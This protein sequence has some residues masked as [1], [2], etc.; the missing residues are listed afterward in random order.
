VVE[1][2]WRWIEPRA[3]DLQDGRALDADELAAAR[4]ELPR[5][6]AFATGLRE[7][8]LQGTGVVWIRGLAGFGRGEAFARRCHELLGCAI[9]KPLDHYGRL[10]EIRDRGVDHVTERVPVS[11]TRAT[12]EFHTDSSR[13]DVLVDLV[14][15]LCERP[16]MHGGDSLV[17]N[18]MCVRDRLA[19]E[20]PE[21]LTLLEQPW[22]RDLV[23]P[24]SETSLEALQANRFPVFDGDPSGADFT[25]RH[26]RLWLERGQK[27]AGRPIDAA[28]AAA[29]D[30]LDAL[31]REPEHSLRLRLDSGDILWV[32]NRA[33]AHDRD[34]YEDDPAAP[35]CLLRMWVDCGRPRPASSAPRP[36]EVAAATPAID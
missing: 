2:L 14:G 26:M 29:L 30:R 36:A 22:I 13:R 33:L 9:G 12:T 17:S 3:G 25:F 31:L 5:L 15:L 1:E 23:T 20:S 18:A 11:M 21:L 16:A 32:D 28:A 24:G 8:L 10:F 35:R 34:G 6:H 7:Q 4:R 27:N 19:A